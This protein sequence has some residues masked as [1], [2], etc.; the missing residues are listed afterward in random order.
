[1]KRIQLFEFEDF[2]W[3]PHSIRSSMTNL[4]VVM[5]KLVGS[6][7][8]IT[9][10]IKEIH[11]HN[12]FSQIVDLGAGSGGIMPEVLQ[13]LNRDNQNPINLL[14]TDLHPSPKFLAHINKKGQ[15]NV[16]YYESSLDATNLSKAP[17]GL[18]TMTNCFH[19]MPPEKAKNILQSAQ[20]NKEPLF[21][22]EMAENN[23]PL[24]LWWIF[25]PISLVILVIMSLFLTPF[26]KPLTMHQLIF[27][28][29]IPIIPIFYAWDGQ[30]SLPRIYTLKDIEELLPEPQEDYIWEM[31]QG[32][33]NN[34][35]KQGY[36]I[37]G[38]PRK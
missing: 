9:K 1:M 38:M 21:I 36:Y 20:K 15:N 19:H 12:N 4:I 28:Y 25:L 13:E 23:I 22:Y 7:E 8:V 14:L 34:G 10:V 32:I 17:E 37:L 5:Q 2:D 24:F 3:F 26:S 33:K 27:T 35:K 30:A 29:L 16:K 6:K 31:A 18:K 11:T